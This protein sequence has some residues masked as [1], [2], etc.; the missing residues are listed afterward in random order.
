MGPVPP[1]LTRPPV[2]DETSAMATRT[3]TDSFGPIEVPA[4]HWW[5][6]QTQRSLR[7]FAI[8]TETMPVPLIR[9]LGLIKEA[10]AG[11]NAKL[12]VLDSAP[13]LPADVVDLALWAADY[14]AAGPGETI[15]SAMPPLKA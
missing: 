3:E 9:A 14:Y 4:E 10:A 8:G 5:G 12:G 15:A 11:V 1:S 2:S 6:A 7:Y 13:F